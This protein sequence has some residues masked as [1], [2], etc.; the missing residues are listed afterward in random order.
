MRWK[1]PAVAEYFPNVH[2]LRL[3]LTVVVFIILSIGLVYLLHLLLAHFELPNIAWLVYLIVFVTSLV[4]NMTI[5]VPVPF[6]AT[7]MIAAATAWN[8]FLVALA[9]S[10]GGSLGELSSYYVGYLGKKIAIRQEGA[11]YKR[12]KGWIQ[13]HGV[14]AILLLSLQPI[15]PFDVAGLIAGAVR[16]PVHK[17]LPPLFLGKIPKNLILIYG[18]IG[19]L[20]LLPEWLR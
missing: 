3:T 1:N 11:A 15:L 7:I 19:L 6:A 10:A 9:A 2:W 20:S 18:G 13:R 8:P 4:A 14:W 5:V 12:I 17:F 16:M